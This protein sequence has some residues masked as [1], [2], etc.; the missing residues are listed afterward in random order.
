V[1][2]GEEVR[3]NSEIELVKQEAGVLA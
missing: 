1:I 3:I 2:L